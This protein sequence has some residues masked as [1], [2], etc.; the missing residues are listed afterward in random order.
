MTTVRTRLAVLATAAA[1]STAGL[2][3]TA[4][5]AGATT[6]PRCGDASLSVTR[7]YVD[8]G[9]GHSWMSLI[10]RNVSGRTCTVYGYPGLDAINSK[11]QALAHASRASGHSST[12]TIK[13]GGYASASVEWLNFNGSTGGACRF[14]SAVNTIV[15]NTSRVHR[16]AVSVSVCQLQVHPTV[17]GTPGYPDYGPAQVYWLEGSKVA[18]VSTNYYLL[19]A[20]NE[21]KSAKIYPSQVKA[22]AQL[23]SLPETGL[24][25]AQ[26]KEARA[27]IGVLDSFFATPGLYY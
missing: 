3:A 24:T 1:L 15:A 13:P 11:G 20:E 17:A 25:A 27:D 16:L 22:L 9:A 14:S 26:I 5:T 2:A 7:T 19:K 8:S 23:I 4:T 21:L 6:V 10:Y 12:V 18:A